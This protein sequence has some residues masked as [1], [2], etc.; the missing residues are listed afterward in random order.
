NF[1]NV[2]IGAGKVASVIGDWAFGCA[3]H[4]DGVVATLSALNQPEGVIYDGQNV[5]VTVE[6]SDCILKV[7]V[8]DQKI[9]PLVGLCG[10]VG[11]QDGLLT[12]P[13]VRLRDPSA[14]AL[15][16]TYAADGNFYFVDAY[17]SGTSYL[18]YV[19]QRPTSVEISGVTI[20]GNS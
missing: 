7:S 8:A 13:A 5:Y 11:Y 6:G 1:L 3:D 15:D 16:P 9:S 4:T 14:L 10:S 2:L 12:D 18:R 17:N 19:N 20:P